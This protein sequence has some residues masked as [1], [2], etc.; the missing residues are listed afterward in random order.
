MNKDSKKLGNGLT[1]K[2][3]SELEDLFRR[4]DFSSENPG[5]D[6]RLRQKIEERLARFAPSGV[7]IRPF[8]SNPSALS[9][10]SPEKEAAA[11]KL[12][13]P[14]LPPD[15]LQKAMHCESPD[16][17]VAL[18]KSCG[19][20]ITRAQAEA[21]LTELEDMDLDEEVLRKVAGG[22]CVSDM[23]KNNKDN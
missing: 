16:E 15:I 12:D 2:E 9:P 20:G 18:A 5:L 4:A 22:F 14:G 7:R 3:V 1:S 17:L 6:A 23:K 10:E 8:R 21:C 13:L 11:P 19:L